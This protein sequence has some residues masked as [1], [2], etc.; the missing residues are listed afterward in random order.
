KIKNLAFELNPIPLQ[1]QDFVQ[2]GFMPGI[3]GY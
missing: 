1:G 3:D 2:H